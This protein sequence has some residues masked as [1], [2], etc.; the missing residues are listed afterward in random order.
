MVISHKKVIEITS[1]TTFLLAAGFYSYRFLMSLNSSLI[2]VLSQ[3]CE[4]QGRGEGPRGRKRLGGG[5]GG[6]GGE[7]Q[8]QS[9]STQRTMCCTATSHA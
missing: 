2:I 9:T 5:G 7:D 3:Y 1:Y 8:T 6:G 4:E